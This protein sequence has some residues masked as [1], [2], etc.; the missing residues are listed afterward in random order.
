[1]LC[2]QPRCNGQLAEIVEWDD[3]GLSPLRI[4]QFEAGWTEVDGVWTL[5]NF[6]RKRIALG[7]P[8]ASRRD[9][10]AKW[11]GVNDGSHLEPCS[12]SAWPTYARCP[13]CGLVSVVTREAVQAHEGAT[14]SAL[15]YYRRVTGSLLYAVGAHPVFRDGVPPNA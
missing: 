10:G 5:S 2:G 9:Y 14:H 4:L 11:A 12:P 1:V 6:A 15:E 8:A 7:R 3:P 13:E